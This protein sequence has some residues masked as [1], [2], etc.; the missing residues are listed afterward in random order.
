MN[1][2]FQFFYARQIEAIIYENA[3]RKHYRFASMW[4]DYYWKHFDEYSKWVKEVKLSPSISDN[5]RVTQICLATNTKETM[6]LEVFFSSLGDKDCGLG[7]TSQLTA[8]DQAE[9][10][11]LRSIDQCLTQ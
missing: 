5:E 7:L 8:F 2:A 10:T 3:E 6:F 9:M 11:L 4:V 1:D